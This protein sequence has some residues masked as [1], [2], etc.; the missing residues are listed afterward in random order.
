MINNE[1]ISFFLKS[2]SYEVKPRG[3]R[4]LP[5]VAVPL[6]QMLPFK[7]LPLNH[8]TDVTAFPTSYTQKSPGRLPGQATNPFIHPS[9]NPG[10]GCVPAR[11]LVHSSFSDGGSLGGGGLSLLKASKAC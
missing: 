3:N 7:L 10:S 2:K 11:Q 6:P 5:V 8:V 4:M 9:I 1:K